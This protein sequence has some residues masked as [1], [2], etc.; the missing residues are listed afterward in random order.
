MKKV[1]KQFIVDTVENYIKN[2]PEEYQEFLQYLAQRRIDLGDRNFGKLKGTTELRVGVSLPRRIYDIFSYVLKGEEK[3]F[4]EEKGE[5]KWF[6]RKY[7][8]FVLPNKY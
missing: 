4:G 8:Q 5:M 2:Y 7:P 6:V 1:R 3:P